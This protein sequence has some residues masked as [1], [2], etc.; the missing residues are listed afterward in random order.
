MSPPNDPPIFALLNEIGIIEHL[1]RNRAERA[2]PDGLRLSHFIVLNHLVRLG[3]G[4][5]L[6]RIA[7]AVQVERPAMTNTI[8]KLEARGLVRGVPDPRD[9][10]GKLVFLT[11]AGRAMREQ[12]VVAMAEAIR[13]VPHGLAAEEIAGL[14]APLRR[15][16]AALDRARDADPDPEPQR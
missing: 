12:G 8:Q 9:G 10:R 11:E 4:R 1:A 7:R 5:S 13:P 3:D 2:L 15:L 6:A 14:L 16:R